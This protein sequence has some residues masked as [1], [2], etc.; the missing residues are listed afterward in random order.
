MLHGQ[1]AME[2]YCEQKQ[3]K[4]PQIYVQRKISEAICVQTENI[5][6]IVPEDSLALKR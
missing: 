1:M 2:Q 4:V 5:G 6:W 3:N